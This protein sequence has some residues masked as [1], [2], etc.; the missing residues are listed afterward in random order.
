V[1]V[2]ISCGATLHFPSFSHPSQEPLSVI[3]HRGAV[4]PSQNP[5][6]H[7]PSAAAAVYS[8]AWMVRRWSFARKTAVRR[9]AAQSMVEFALVLPVLLALFFVIIESGRLFQAWLSV[10]NSARFAVRYAVTGD[11]DPQYCDLPT[12]RSGIPTTTTYSI[13]LG[14]TGSTMPQPMPLTAHRSTAL[15]Q[16]ILFPPR[17]AWMWIR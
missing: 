16:S 5:E 13:R 1:I 17:Q 3:N 12:T 2:C 10:Q 6:V 9:T 14:Q 15:C 8:W 4:L 7:L 11:F